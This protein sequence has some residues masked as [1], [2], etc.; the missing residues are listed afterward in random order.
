VGC[1]QADEAAGVQYDYFDDCE[2]VRVDLCYHG[3]LF[4]RVDHLRRPDNIDNF[5]HPLND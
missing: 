4:R 3:H 2:H 5:Y 1:L